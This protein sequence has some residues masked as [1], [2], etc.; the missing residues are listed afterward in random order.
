MTEIST[1]YLAVFIALFP[2]VNPPG[3]A[4][5]FIGA[6]LGC[7]P[8]TRQELAGRIAL[9]SFLIMTISLFVGSHVLAFFGLSIPAI[10][11]GGGL[12]VMSAG[13][14]LLNRPAVTKPDAVDAAVSDASV[15]QHWFVP[16]TMPMTVGPGTIS[17]A[18]TLGSRAAGAPG[19][20]LLAIG[21]VAALITITLLIYICYRYGETVLN[22]LGT[23]GTDVV[24]RLAAFI[25]LC[26]GVQ[27]VINGIVGLRQSGLL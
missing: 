11:I 16:L 25:L 27:I 19:F 14:Q 22:R 18:I 10:Q 12:L 23:G 5:F 8:R 13:W 17:V 2:I 3:M 24:Q 7:S 9:S 6:T 21:A 4:P 20:P 26:I 15:Q 1:A